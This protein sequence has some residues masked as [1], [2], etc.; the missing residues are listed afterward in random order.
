M[1]IQEIRFILYAPKMDLAT[2]SS[3][4]ALQFLVTRKITSGS[5]ARVTE[6]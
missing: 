5:L 6:R 4:K 1:K 3:E 2:L